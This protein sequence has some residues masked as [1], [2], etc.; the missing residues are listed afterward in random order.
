MNS[1]D[2]HRGQPVLA[3]GA[4]LSE[5][6]GAVI[7]IH[8]RGAGAE[9]IIGLS[10]A[11]DRP[12][13]AYLAPEA[14]G[15]VW[16]PRPFMTP[17]AGNEPWLTSAKGVIAA[18]IAEIARNG[19]PL[20]RTA[21][22]G[23]SQGASL[24]LEYAARNPARYGGVLALSGGLI[25]EAIPLSSYSGSLEGTP[26]L[27]ACSDV[28]QFIPLQRVQDSAAVMAH[29][30]ADVTERIYPRMGHTI[31]PDEVAQVRRIL[32]AMVAAPAA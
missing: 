32:D 3:T 6:T 10:G 16:Y 19:I 2:P 14:A 26:V 15:R 5:A 23:F 25:G 31:V 13:L 24:S 29:L 12:G 7:M 17:V 4:P 30:G 27:V 28:D 21:L 22:L 1:D 9:D 11:I 8:G 20:E 18:I